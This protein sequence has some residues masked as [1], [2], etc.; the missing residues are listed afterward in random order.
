MSSEPDIWDR[1]AADGL[2]PLCPY[3]DGHPPANEVGGDA[4]YPHRSDLHE[5]R[6]YVCYDCEALVGCHPGT[7]K[8]LGR[9]A[10]A[11]LRRAKSRA[12]A[13][14]DPL[15]RGKKRGARSAAYAWLAE[16]MGLKGRDCHFGM[17]SERLC[18][19]AGRLA[20]ER[21]KELTDG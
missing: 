3:C 17:M 15:W 13:A 11:Q 4:V 16:A 7:N 8:P 5:K 21:R 10:N 9:L 2:T 1:R 19:E 12:H 18:N 20:R 14:F 6:F